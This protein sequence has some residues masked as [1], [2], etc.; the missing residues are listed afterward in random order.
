[1]MLLP[2]PMGFALSD[3]VSDGIIAISVDGLPL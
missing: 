3:A 1:M 2:L